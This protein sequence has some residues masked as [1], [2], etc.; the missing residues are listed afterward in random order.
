MGNKPSQPYLNAPGVRTYKMMRGVSTAARTPSA[1]Q[2]PYRRRNAPQFLP[3]RRLPQNVA[4][5]HRAHTLGLLRRPMNP[6]LMYLDNE[7]NPLVEN[8]ANAEDNVLM[9]ERQFG[10]PLPG[11]RRSDEFGD[12]HDFQ[13]LAYRLLEALRVDNLQGAQN[14]LVHLMRHNAKFRTSIDR[15][16]RVINDDWLMD[17]WSLDDYSNATPEQLGSVPFDD[18]DEAAVLIAKRILKAR[19]DVLDYYAALLQFN[20]YLTRL[21]PDVI[22]PDELMPPDNMTEVKIWYEPGWIF[23]STLNQDIPR[24]LKLASLKRNGHD[25]VRE[26]MQD[27]PPLNYLPLALK[28]HRV[29]TP[30]TGGTIVNVTPSHRRRRRTHSANTKHLSRRST[31]K[32][33]VSA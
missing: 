6:T 9:Y 18:G 7:M 5:E 17:V 32:R 4:L 28:Y 25:H 22:G 23:Q 2:P 30:Y 3:A 1:V 11:R 12:E 27:A 19:R 10:L 29:P 21:A 13:I 14:A 15:L 16:I 33:A 8:V 20:E 26:L 24:L 31:S